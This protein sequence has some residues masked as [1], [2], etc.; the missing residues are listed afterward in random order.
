M[1]K[2][3]DTKKQTKKKPAMTMQEKKAAKRAGKETR[4]SLR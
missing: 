4:G 2:G 1:S 3:R